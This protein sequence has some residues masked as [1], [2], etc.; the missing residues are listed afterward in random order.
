VTAVAHLLPVIGLWPKTR[1]HLL[2]VSSGMLD[3]RFDAER[4]EAEG[5]KL[6]GDQNFEEAYA[7]GAAV[8]V[9]APVA[10]QLTVRR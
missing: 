4:I 7:A 6:L 2:P 9:E 3:D 5:R 10:Q 8:D 1:M